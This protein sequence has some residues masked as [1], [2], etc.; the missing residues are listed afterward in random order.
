LGNNIQYT[1]GISL[2]SL[3]TKYIAS[4]C[5]DF[6]FLTVLAGI[7]PTIKSNSYMST[8]VAIFTQKVSDRAL[9]DIKAQIN[10]AKVGLEGVNDTL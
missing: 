3:L 4:D 9:G 1:D 5:I 8:Q 6:S 7:Y 10:A 2:F